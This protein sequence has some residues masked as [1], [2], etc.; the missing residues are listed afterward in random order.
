M[1][2]NGY[3]NEATYFASLMIDNER[4]LYEATRTVSTSEELR[5]KVTGA[6]NG[7]NDLLGARAASSW[8]ADFRHHGLKLGDVHWG[9][10]LGDIRRQRVEVMSSAAHRET[11]TMAEGKVLAGGPFRRK[12]KA[13][14]APTTT[15]VRVR[16]HTRSKP[17]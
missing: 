11:S 17:Q 6:L 13:K 1:S 9:D 2:H 5:R 7:Q 3:A 14:K 16:A 12:A 8:R 4:R 10:L 15:R